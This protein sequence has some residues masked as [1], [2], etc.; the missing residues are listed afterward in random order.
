METLA[1]SVSNSD[2]PLSEKTLDTSITKSSAQSMLKRKI[3]CD[4]APERKKSRHSRHHLLRHVLDSSMTGDAALKHYD[5]V[6]TIEDAL[7][8]TS[9]MSQK[10]LQTTFAKVYGMKSSSNN[11]NWLRK[12]LMEALSPTGWRDAWNHYMSNPFSNRGKKDRLRKIE[13]AEKLQKSYCC[14]VIPP[15]TE[16]FAKHG[17]IGQWVKSH[18]QRESTHASNK[19]SDNFQGCVTFQKQ[20][21]PWPQYLPH[22]NSMAPLHPELLPGML[23]NRESLVFPD[24]PSLP[25]Q[26]SDMATREII[27]LLYDLVYKRRDQHRCLENGNRSN[28]KESTVEAS[29]LISSSERGNNFYPPVMMTNVKTE[30]SPRIEGAKEHA[31]LLTNFQPDSEVIDLLQSWMKSKQQ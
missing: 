27:A 6:S 15:L 8:L 7:A 22:I 1:G 18:H 10:D 19:I 9:A 14:D 17:E 13:R 11:N 24:M 2:S 21:Q 3:E 28:M 20:L 30:P 31:P 4:G 12:K 23:Q 5:G 29:S 16:S 25:L 26:K